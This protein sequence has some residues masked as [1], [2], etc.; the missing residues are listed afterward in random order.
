LIDSELKN[1]NRLNFLYEWSSTNSN[2]KAIIY[3]QTA[4]KLYFKTFL[5]SN[6]YAFIQEDCDEQELSLCLKNIFDGKGMIF[7]KQSLMINAGRD[8][9]E[10][11][12]LQNL[13]Q[14]EKIY[15]T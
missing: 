12:D 4:E 14:R 13:T 11:L 7:I 1:C 8:D 3:S 2:T 5:D 6:A 15:G 10:S 9:D